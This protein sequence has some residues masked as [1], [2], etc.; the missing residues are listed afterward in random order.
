MAEAKALLTGLMEAKE[1][2]CAHVVMES[3]SFQVIQSLQKG[4]RGSS[5]FH[6]VLDDILALVFDFESVIFFS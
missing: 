3:D 1:Q 4:V 2:G 6:L 5:D